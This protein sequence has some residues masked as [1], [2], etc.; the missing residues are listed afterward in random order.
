MSD[1]YDA[2]DGEIRAYTPGVAPPFELLAD[3]RRRQGRRRIALGSATLALALVAAGGA[4]RLD[5]FER[6]SSGGLAG[7]GASPTPE[8]GLVTTEAPVSGDTYVLLDER[9][10]QVQVV[11][12]GGCQ[13][14]GK[15]AGV[16]GQGVE[17][18]QLSV[19]VT[20]HER[21]SPPPQVC[22]ANVILENVVVHLAEPLGTRQVI[23]EVRHQ[24]L[25]LAPP[26][27]TSVNGP[28][29][30]APPAG[31]LPRT[32]E[33]G[34]VTAVTGNGADLSVTVDRVDMLSGSAADAAARADGTQVDGDYYLN[35]D[36][37][38]ARTYRVAANAV[39]WGSIQ[40]APEPWPQRV[41]V[42]RWR[43][44]AAQHLGDRPPFH[45]MVE[46]GVVTGIEQQYL[47]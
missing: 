43:E 31:Y 33:F 37:S 30:T 8:P 45:F 23:D 22:T 17:K 11:V 16:V 40:L 13:E 29:V 42:Q 6:P 34:F 46:N 5:A 39:V 19:T 41:T 24:L 21:T 1:L 47:P 12:G 26:E 38:L 9:T 10:L 36:S 4:W 15:A 32:D 28:G 44:F 27:Q 18:V 14:T 25:R 20:R 2:V 7:D 3:R 35:N